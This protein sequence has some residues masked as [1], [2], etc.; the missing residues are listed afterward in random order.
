VPD[1]SFTLAAAD[2]ITITIDGIGTVE[3][4]VTVV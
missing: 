3:N 2:R 1:E 4:T